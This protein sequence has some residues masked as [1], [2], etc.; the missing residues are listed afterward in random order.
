MFDGACGL[1]HQRRSRSIKLAKI[2]K[3]T[4]PRVALLGSETLL[5]HELEEVLKQ[6]PLAPNVTTY[7]ASGEGNFA[8]KD[9]EAVYRD[10]FEPHSLQGEEAILVAGSLEGAR[11]VY[12]LVKLANGVPTVIDGTYHLEQEPEARIVAPLLEDGNSQS[13]WLLVVAHPA[14]LAIAMTLTRL[15]K[16]QPL[17]Q[18]V[19]T[20][21]EPATERGKTGASELHQ[22]TTSLLSFKPLEKKIFDAQLAFN[23]FAVL[24]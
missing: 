20:V 19:F 8:D 5:G 6:M 1:D 7:A 18:A 15:M 4:T 17:R 11:K 21:F 14:A 10:P 13:G 16:R 9:G 12:N 3:I 24:W 22:Q 2:S 23:L